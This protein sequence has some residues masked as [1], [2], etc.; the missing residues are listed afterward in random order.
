MQALILADAAGEYIQAGNTRM[1]LRRYAASVRRWP[2]SRVRWR[3][4]A[5]LAIRRLIGR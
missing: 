4:V 2:M 1:A 3:A 5:S